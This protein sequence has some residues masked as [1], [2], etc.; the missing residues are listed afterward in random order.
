MVIVLGAQVQKL[1][2]AEILQ[3]LGC[4]RDKRLVYALLVPLVS[5]EAGQ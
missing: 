5:P 2:A 3:S 4:A 1:V